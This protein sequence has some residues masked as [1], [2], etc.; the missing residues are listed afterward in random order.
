MSDRKPGIYRDISN[1]EYHS[2]E[3]LASSHLRELL[4]SPLHYI[5]RVNTPSKETPAMKL[6]TAVHCA[7]LEP[8][9]FEI[10]YIEAPIIDRRTKDGKVLW[11]ELE[12][13]GRIVLSSDEY[14]KVTQ[15]A[16]AVRNH[17]IASKLISGGVA[18][19]SVYWNQRVSLLDVSEIFC[20]A[21]PDYLK[22]LKR[23]Y[24][25]VD[26]KTTQ[27]ASISEFPKK[28]YYQWL[29]HLQAAHYLRGFEAVTGE[30]VIAFMYIA[31]ESELPYAIS[32][33][34]A[35]DDYL[36]A[37]KKKTQELYELYANCVA[38]DSWP[39]YSSDI[40]ELRLPKWAS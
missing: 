17:E 20:K 3:G 6:G 21:R 9:R 18:E 11:S 10:E 38:N 12:Q 24:V 32:V 31:I 27:D 1:S 40:Q 34:K 26:I 29:Y 36:E 8:E 37:G 33:F 16:N 39:S 13:S 25:I 19:Q 2:G 35:G 30:K 7:I 4:R 14:T 28:A 22:P 5:T 15:M 23:G